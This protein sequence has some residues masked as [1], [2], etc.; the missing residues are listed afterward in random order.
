[1]CVLF[2]FKQKTA[3]EMRI[4][5]WSSDGCSSDLGD[6]VVQ[7]RLAGLDLDAGALVDLAQL[8][9][10][11]TAGVHGVSGEDG[12]ALDSTRL[13]AALPPPHEVDVLRRVERAVLVDLDRDDLGP[14]L[15]GRDYQLDQIG[16][17]A[18]R[19]RVCECVQSEVDA[20]SLKKTR[21]K[22]KKSIH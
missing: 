17:A 5:D 1:M 6:L 10:H 13:G 16:R 20:V 4:R 22:I 14:Q 7:G 11:A 8:V 12:L 3:Y 19:E 15:D 18:G 2:L 9:H 21:I